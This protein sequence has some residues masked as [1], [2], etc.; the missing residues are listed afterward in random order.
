MEED[1]ILNIC[2]L[3]LYGILNIKGNSYSTTGKTMCILVPLSLPSCIRQFIPNSPSSF[4][5]ENHLCK[6]TCTIQ[7][8]FSKTEQGCIQPIVKSTWYFICLCGVNIFLHNDISSTV[9]LS[10]FLLG[11]SLVFL[12]KIK[13]GRPHFIYRTW[14]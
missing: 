6:A 13:S 8:R 11:V 10:N 9:Y 5:L 2:Y 14:I 12:M 7:V 4:H 1:H 3:G